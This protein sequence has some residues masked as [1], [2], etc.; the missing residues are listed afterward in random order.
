MS[1]LLCHHFSKEASE[2]WKCSLDVFILNIP[3]NV[4]KSMWTCL[5]TLWFGFSFFKVFYVHFRLY[6]TECEWSRQEMEREVDGIRCNHSATKVL[7]IR[8][9][10]VW[11]SFPSY[12]ILYNDILVC[13]QTYSNTLGKIFSCF[14]IYI[15]YNISV[16]KPRS[17]KKWFQSL[18]WKNLTSAPSN[19]F[20]D[21]IHPYESCSLGAYVEKVSMGF[22]RVR[23]V[24][25]SLAKPGGFLLVPR[26]HGGDKII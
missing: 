2:F 21:L 19:T 1:L 6:Y 10:M 13:F 5:S 9:F 18:V 20:L 26:S 25:P 15:I 14:N 11:A 12:Q 16:H 24:E 8:V 3:N 23:S 22:H 7:L 4:A 17:I